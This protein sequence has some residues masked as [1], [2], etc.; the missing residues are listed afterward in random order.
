[1]K[2]IFILLAILM[3]TASISFANDVDNLLSTPDVVLSRSSEGFIQGTVTLSGGAGNVVDV[4]VTA[5]GV[6]VNPASNGDYEIE[7]LEGTYDVT[8]SLSGY[9]TETVYGVVVTAEQTTTGIDFTLSTSI[10][11]SIPLSVGWNWFSL[12]IYDA[13][14]SLN[15]VLNSLG[16]NG[17]T[18]KDQTSYAQYLAGYGWVGSL[19]DISNLTYYRIEMTNADDLDFSGLAFDVST[20]IPVTVGWNWVSYLPQN[21]MGVN[22]ALISLDNNGIT[23]KNQTSYAQYLAGY[24]WIG[25]LANMAPLDGYSLQMANADDLIYPSSDLD[26]LLSTPD[27]VL[28]RSS[29]GFIQGTVTLSGGSGNVVDVEVTADGVTVN[30]ASNG[31]YEIE[32]LE[33]TYD[34]TA[35]LSGYTTETVYG[36]VVTAEQTTTG[37]DFTLDEY[38][39][40]WTVNPALYEYNGSITA[41][42][43]DT[44]IQVSSA[45]DLIGA[46]CGEECRGVQGTYEF[47]P[48]SGEYI[49]FL[50]VYANNASGDWLT[51]KYWDSV[52]DLVYDIDET[53]EFIPDMMHGDPAN[54]FAMNITTS[55]DVSIPLSVGWNWFS[56]NI[57]DAD[58]SLNTVLNS[59]GD[60]GTTIKDQTS[61]AQYLA[62]Y[63]WVGSLVDISNLTY[64]RIEMTNADDLDFSGLAFDVSTPIPVTVGW[65]WVSYLPQNA[66]GVNDALISL[67]NNG[68]TIKNQTSYAQYLA[69]YGWIGSLANMAPLDGYSLQMAN[70]DDLIYPGTAMSIPEEI[71]VNN[72]STKDN[73][74]W[75]VNPALYEHNGGITCQALLS[76]GLMFDA[77]AGDSIGAFCGEECRGVQ[78]TY[79]FPPGSGEYIYFLMVYANN[80][81]GDWLTFKYWDSVADLVYDIDETL[82]F[83][84]DMMHGDPL[85]PFAMHFTFGIDDPGIPSE[86][87]LDQNYPNPFTVNTT[88]YYS[89]PK[90]SDV[91]IQIY[92]L[93]GQL[94]ETLLK[95]QKSRGE[96]EVKW[97][98]EAMSSGVYFYKLI[99]DTKVICRKM[100]L[101][102]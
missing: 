54:P 84:P 17:T 91:E 57:Y 28:S 85:N 13:D 6:T 81:S 7:I 60:N 63:G 26:D 19:V 62:G 100:L 14:M 58:M 16:D 101:V 22:D 29:E 21:A 38:G 49:Y 37:I 87:T 15:T 71:V 32:I 5:D 44:G 88:I 96:Y 36:V 95:E 61:Y 64:Y 52:A 30:P 35:S 1:M 23:I 74:G 102:K 10:D 92:N 98:G 11:V 20:P 12:N 99:T 76:D 39:P 4:E 56:L 27:F 24:G 48:G 90:D 46:F 59:L 75:T 77:S 47:P 2:R 55:I 34:V 68:I 69:G 67:D 31:D 86:L 80:A 40:G 70:A 45:G 78:G 83:I 18:I 42:V 8:A 82:E 97:N 73:P 94:V 93:K 9:T 41:A 33:G 3:I 50:M 25:S 43:F 66:M 53:L 79:E 65:N 72:K 51:F 89:I